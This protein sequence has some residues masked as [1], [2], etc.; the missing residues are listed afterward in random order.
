DPMTAGSALVLVRELLRAGGETEDEFLAELLGEPVAA[1]S[2][3]L[4]AARNEP[5][6]M[7]EHRRRAFLGWMGERLREGPLLCVLEDLQWA[8][9][10][11]V[12]YMEEALR[13]HAERPWLVLAL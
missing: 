4:R 12:A 10:A 7:R 3:R 11:S 13:T 1:P 2:E 9:A 5:A 6:M 8:D